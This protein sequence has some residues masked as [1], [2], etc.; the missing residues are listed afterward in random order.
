MREHG[1]NVLDTEAID[2]FNTFLPSVRSNETFPAFDFPH[3]NDEAMLS[4]TFT[5]L[6]ISKLIDD[7]YIRSSPGSDAASPKIFKINYALL[8]VLLS[9]PFQQCLESFTVPSNWRHAYVKCIFRS[10]R[11]ANSS[12]YRPT[13][14]T[15]AARK[16]R[17]YVCHT[18][19]QH[20]S[21]VARLTR[22]RSTHKN[23]IRGHYAT[24]S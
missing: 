13:L 2:K 14:P 4:T 21:I 24:V 1:E 6:A 18:D 15:S 22:L 11:K 19:T 7:L 20:H 12:N 10:G 17:E 23:R 16:P 5:P 9:K 8:S 3:V